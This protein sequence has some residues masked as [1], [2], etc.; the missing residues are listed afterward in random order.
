MY[1]LLVLGIFLTGSAP[2]N[3]LILRF[4]TNSF[5]G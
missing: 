5:P 3:E 1:T 4:R 2:E